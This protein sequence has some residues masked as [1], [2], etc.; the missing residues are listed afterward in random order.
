MI[1]QENLLMNNQYLKF[2]QN[3]ID[4]L[5]KYRKSICGSPEPEDDL[6]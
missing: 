6:F 4:L 5:D 1:S 3:R 2:K